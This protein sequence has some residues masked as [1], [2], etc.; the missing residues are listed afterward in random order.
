MFQALKW[1]VDQ[2]LRAAGF[3][4]SLEWEDVTG[5]DDLRLYAGAL[6]PDLAQYETHVGLN[7]FRWSTRSIR[8]DLTTPFPLPDNSVAAFQSEDVFEHIEYGQL[9]P[10]FA[11]VY[12]VLR[13][14]GLFRM[15]LPD[16]R[17]DFLRDR[18]LKAPDGALL[19]DPDGGGTYVDG[20]VVDGGHVWLPTIETVQSLYDGSPFTDVRIL[21][22]TMPDG[23]YRLE[24][25]DYSLGFVQRTPDHDAR[26]QFPRRPFSIVVDAYK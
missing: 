13:P 8:H 10:I 18:C 3:L 15:S 2:R 11:E 9:P 21:H 6:T 7:P 26:A 5:R 12:R 24:P 14:G 25:I 19:H 4:R 22:A 20:N 23:S 17:V 1:R 16:Y